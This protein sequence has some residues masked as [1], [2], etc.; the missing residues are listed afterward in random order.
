MFLSAPGILEIT[1]P[2]NLAQF[3]DGGDAARMEHTWN[4]LKKGRGTDISKGL[5][6]CHMFLEVFT[7]PQDKSLQAYLE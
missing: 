7:N 3:R 6:H 2:K 5:I 1:R 4:A